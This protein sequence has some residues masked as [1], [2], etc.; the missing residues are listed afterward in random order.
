MRV[1]GVECVQKGIVWELDV[2]HSNFKL[3]LKS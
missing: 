1:D 2:S 3:F